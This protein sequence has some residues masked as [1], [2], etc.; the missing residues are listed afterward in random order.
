MQ[1]ARR[2]LYL[3]SAPAGSGALAQSGPRPL[4]QAVE[5]LGQ[6][7]GAVGVVAPLLH[8]CEVRLVGLGVRWRG[9][10]C[11]VLAG[12]QATPRAVPELRDSRIAGEAGHRLVPVAAP[13]RNPDPRSRLAALGLT[14]RPSSDAA[15]ANGV[16]TTHCSPLAQ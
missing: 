5:G 8:V 2:R 10:V 11:L 1:A 13:E 3:L 12:G 16:A 14:H 9:R 7:R 4:P 15:A 6:D